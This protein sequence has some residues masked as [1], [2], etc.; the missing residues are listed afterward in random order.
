MTL[1]GASA[2]PSK[3]NA[4][5]RRFAD[6]FE[7]LTARCK[8]TD[9]A[10]AWLRSQIEAIRLQARP[11]GA[12]HNRS[13]MRGPWRLQLTADDK[14]MLHRARSITVR[15]LMLEQLA[16]GSQLPEGLIDALGPE[17]DADRAKRASFEVPAQWSSLSRRERE[18]ARQVA[19]RFETQPWA[20]RPGMPPHPA[21]RYAV[22]TAR[23]IRVAMEGS[24]RTPKRLLPFGK[25]GAVIKGPAA[26]LLRTAL[27]YTLPAGIAVPSDRKLAELLSG[28]NR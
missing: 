9:D 25:H 24:G 10:A 6:R 16:S 8:L 23:A 12:L 18:R 13:I 27:R 21:E 7:R 15:D 1:G 4:A 14:A 26:D 20:F 3:T 5:G 11:R 28:S 2:E 19:R 22:E 17:T